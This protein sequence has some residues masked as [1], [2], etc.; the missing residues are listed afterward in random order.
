[1]SQARL[2]IRCAIPLDAPAAS[3]CGVADGADTK[4]P[5]AATA[6]AAAT[7]CARLDVEGSF[8]FRDLPGAV[9]PHAAGSTRV[10][11]VGVSSQVPAGP[12]SLVRSFA[13]DRTP[14]PTSLAYRVA[15]QRVKFMRH[16]EAE[17]A[18]Q[19]T[20]I[21]GALKGEKKKKKDCNTAHPAH[22]AADSSDSIGT[23]S[24]A[25]DAELEENLALVEA[26][27]I[28]EELDKFAGTGG[29]DE[30]CTATST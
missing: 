10:Y 15:E 21:E 28:A 8:R 6:A 3:A 14:L 23:R 4:T 27:K 1:M 20:S 9:G 24:L 13:P 5:A 17:A 19:V 2:S 22:P 16:M 30:S 26:L 11:S 25:G 18:K 29:G 7:D 12:V